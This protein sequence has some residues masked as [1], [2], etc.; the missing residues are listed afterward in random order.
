MILMNSNIHH[1][2]PHHNGPHHK[3]G[4]GGG[5]TRGQAVDLEHIYVYT[6]IF[7]RTPRALDSLIAPT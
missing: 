1:R 7:A 5:G 6:R 4:G 2:E 3:G